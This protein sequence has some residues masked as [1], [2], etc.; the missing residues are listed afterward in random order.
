VCVCDRWVSWWMDDAQIHG[1]M[2]V[3]GWLIGWME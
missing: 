2:E 1:W 3:D